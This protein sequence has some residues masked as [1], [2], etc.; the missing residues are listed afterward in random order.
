MDRL[1]TATDRLP[2][3]GRPYPR[4]GRFRFHLRAVVRGAKLLSALAL[5]LAW[6][7]AAPLRAE[8]KPD[9][10]RPVLVIEIKGAIGVATSEFI[11]RALVRARAA[12]A[13]MLIIRLDTPGG[14]V[15]STRE[16]I[17][18]ML[19]SPVPVAVF[20][21]PPGA[22]AASAGTYMI[23]AA[24]VAAMARG[25]HLGAATPI[26]LTA[27]GTSSRDTEKDKKDGKDAMS[28]S[29]R[30]VVNDAVA[31]LRALAQLRGRNAAWAER[32]VRTADTL[33]ATEAAK[34]NVIDL[35]AADI[36]DL[37][38]KADG[39]TVSVAGAEMRLETKGAPVVALEADWR[40]KI[41][42]VIGD[43]T[44]AYLLLLLGVYGILFEFWSPGAVAPGVIGGISLLLG[45]GALTV[46]PV[47]F[48]GLGLVALGIGLM[49]AEA[50]T[51]SIGALGIGGLAAF[52][53]GSVLL[54]DPD[55]A[56]GVDFR[57]P[58]PA[59]AVA[60]LASALFFMFAL[61]LA[62]RARRRPVVSGRERMIGSA[63]KVV[64][65]EAGKGTVR[66]QG[67]VWAAR[68]AT[69]LFPGDPVRI[70]ELE[71]LTVIVEP[72]PGARR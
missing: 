36:P 15:S 66:V 57:V 72:G 68:S 26:S 64:S 5:A 16:I 33:I 61:G 17:H 14:L 1:R 48:A 54:F 2:R 13:R 59:I 3:R 71:R 7:G 23:Y 50:F 52:V 32:A 24:H 20:V 41:L 4:Y 56:P 45:L 19:A 8:T 62:W 10:P 27:P 21:A 47:D 25:T 12:R 49:A 67:E 46:L 65:W 6:L 69:P 42:S 18:A 31:Y 11:A 43:P 28:A 63:G 22:R 37:L 44:V 53:A 35:I 40:I 38:A 70:V 60:A 51:P 55:A 30:K 9:V 39:R 34:E 29:E 58:W